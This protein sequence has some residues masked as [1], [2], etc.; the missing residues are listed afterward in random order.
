MIENEDLS[1]S[2]AE[3]DQESLTLAEQNERAEKRRQK[4]E[5]RADLLALTLQKIIRERKI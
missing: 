5:K 2:S 4:T 1:D 3:I